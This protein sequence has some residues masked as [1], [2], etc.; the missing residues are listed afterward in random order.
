MSRSASGQPTNCSRHPQGPGDTRC[1]MTRPGACRVPARR[2]SHRRPIHKGR[3]RL[4][5]RPPMTCEGAQSRVHSISAGHG[6]MTRRLDVSI[7]SAARRSC[8]GRLLAAA[9]AEPGPPFRVTG[10][11]GRC[12]LPNRSAPPS[13]RRR[14]VGPALGPVRRSRGPWSERTDKHAPRSPVRTG[15][16]SVESARAAPIQG[17]DGRKWERNAFPA[18]PLPGTAAPQGASRPLHQ[19]VWRPR[20]WCGIASSARGREVCR[21][22]PAGISRGDARRR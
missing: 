18:R 8:P 9:A 10:L 16:K 11:A 12:G 4:G 19:M 20:A 3:D 17:V 5:Y 15:G 7:Y 13:G 22:E 21:Y 6:A 1:T 14:W 2:A